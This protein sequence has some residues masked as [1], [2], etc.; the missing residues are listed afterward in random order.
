[1]FVEETRDRKKKEKAG[2]VKLY[3][4]GFQSSTGKASQDQK[5][6]ISC[7]LQA[8]LCALQLYKIFFFSNKIANARDLFR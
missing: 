6:T 3:S 5:K 7:A 4:K 2:S 1:M 8:V